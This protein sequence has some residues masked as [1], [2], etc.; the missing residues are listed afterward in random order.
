MIFRY[1]LIIICLVLLNFSCQGKREALGADNEIR[2]ICSNL[3]REIIEEY[4]SKIFI[5]TLFTPEPEP[6]YNLKFSEPDKYQE[7]KTQSQVIV[8]AVNRQTNNSGYNLVK[9]LLTPE[10]FN[11]TEN[12][13]PT[14]ITR[15]LYANK[16]LFMIINANSKKQLF[17]TID[18]KKG[19]YRKLF[20]DQFLDRQ[21]RFL[22]GDDRNSL[23]SDSLKI[24]FGWSI[25]IPWGWE[26]IKKIPDSN[27]V[28]LGKEMPFQWI[29]IGWVNGNIVGD[30]LSLG[31]YLWGWPRENY[32]FIQFNDHKF[33]LKKIDYNGQFAWRAQGLWETIDIKESKGG[34]FKSYLFYESKT[35]KTYHINYLIHYPGKNKSIFMRQ[36][37]MIV[38]TFKIN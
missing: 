1:L 18:T 25:M 4:L 12:D 14:I 36:M 38:K 5:D 26:L 10:Q 20:H 33:D 7:L 34:P 9:Q 24:E 16:Q 23:L 17:S 3:D 8:A 19:F 30:E 2:V 28:W 31:K 35:D 6:F 32:G 21:K 27:F 13:D 11:Q 15:N 37:D 22:F 29:G